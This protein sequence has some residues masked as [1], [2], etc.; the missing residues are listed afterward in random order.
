MQQWAED[1]NCLEMLPTFTR[2]KANEVEDLGY[3]GKE[4]LLDIDDDVSAEQKTNFEMAVFPG[5]PNKQTLL[6]HFKTKITDP[7]EGV[8]LVTYAFQIIDVELL[9]AILRN[10]DVAMLVEDEIKRRSR[11]T[12]VKCHA[13][14]SAFRGN[15]EISSMFYDT[16]AILDVNLDGSW[17]EADMT[18]T[19]VVENKYRPLAEFQAQA[20][21][22]IMERDTTMTVTEA[23]TTIRINMNTTVTISDFEGNTY[24]LEKPVKDFGDYRLSEHLAH[25]LREKH[26]EFE[27]DNKFRLITYEGEAPSKLG[28]LTSEEP[29]CLILAW[30]EAAEPDAMDVD[31]PMDVTPAGPGGPAAARERWGDYSIS[32]KPSEMAIVRSA[33]ADIS[34]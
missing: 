22:V 34:L 16:P 7:R 28:L 25:L 4:D 9:V 3:L 15:P 29:G 13:F 30:P 33:F 6:E 1:N 12:L 23:T 5:P 20:M 2:W 8:R 14:I 24:S 21:E 17:T 18:M 11:P 32:V 27:T 19:Y 10:K 26:P 31:M